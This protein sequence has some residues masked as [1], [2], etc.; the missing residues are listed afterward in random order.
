MLKDLANGNL[1]RNEM[2]AIWNF[3]WYII[4]DPFEFICNMII[5]KL[6]FWTCDLWHY[7]IHMLHGQI[8]RKIMEFLSLDVAIF[9]W[10]LALQVDILCIVCCLIL[11]SKGIWVSI[12]HS[13][14]LD[15]SPLVRSFQLLTFKFMLRISLFISFPLL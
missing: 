2:L 12:W 7:G 5:M 4:K 6:L 10:C 3:I 15:C 8:W 14:L 1:L 11:M 9:I 13:C